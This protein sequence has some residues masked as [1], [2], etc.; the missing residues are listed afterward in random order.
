MNILGYIAIISIIVLSIW[1][2]HDAILLFILYINVQDN[3][4]KDGME[5]K[6]ADRESREDI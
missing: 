4:T 2:I 6:D 3:E 5:N 1:L